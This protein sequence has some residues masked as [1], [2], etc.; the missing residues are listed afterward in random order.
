MHKKVCV[1]K[2]N[3]SVICNNKNGMCFSYVSSFPSYC[4][5]AVVCLVPYVCREVS[6]L[7]GYLCPSST[8]KHISWQQYLQNAF[9]KKKY[10]LCLHI[11]RVPLY[12]IRL[13]PFLSVALPLF[14][15]VHSSS[16]AQQHQTLSLNRR[17]QVGS[18]SRIYVLY[19]CNCIF[20][21]HFHF[22]RFFYILLYQHRAIM[23]ADGY[24][25]MAETKRIKKFMYFIARVDNHM[26]CSL[27]LLLFV[28]SCRHIR[29]P[30][31]MNA[32]QL[33]SDVKISVQYGSILTAT[34]LRNNVH[35]VIHI[36]YE[37]VS[38][39]ILFVMCCCNSVTFFLYL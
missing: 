5:C 31:R 23:L 17:A 6:T 18:L 29:A 15:S 16:C 30:F 34:H 11:S 19:V 32:V 35:C 3:E 25:M 33:D 9:W 27:L 8:R 39:C 26:S 7:P 4:F 10:H 2:K 13:S 24:G 28:V 1:C 22:I 20:S 14:R 12:R 36:V 38:V 37:C 21:S